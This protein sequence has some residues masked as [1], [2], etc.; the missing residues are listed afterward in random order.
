MGIAH[1]T[2]KP[3]H[4]FPNNCI[5]FVFCSLLFL[6]ELIAVIIKA[7]IST[8]SAI[9]KYQNKIILGA[10]SIINISSICIIPLHKT[11]SYMKVRNLCNPKSRKAIRYLFILDCYFIYHQCFITPYDPSYNKE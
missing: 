10:F 1:I 11:D 8:K 4:I 6:I 9:I 2:P 5:L 7:I 3:K